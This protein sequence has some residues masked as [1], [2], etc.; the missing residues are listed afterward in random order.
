[1]I[2]V[3]IQS[4][5]ITYGVYHGNGDDLPTVQ[6]ADSGLCWAVGVFAKGD[7]DSPVVRMEVLGPRRSGSDH[8]EGNSSTNGGGYANGV[9][10]DSSASTARVCLM[11]ADGKTHRVLSLPTVDEM[12]GSAA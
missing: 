1:M 6:L 7:N 8:V 4:L 10:D 11:H 12:F 3:P 5:K 2:V 9:V